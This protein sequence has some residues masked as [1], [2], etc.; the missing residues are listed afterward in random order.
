MM[1]IYDIDKL[2]ARAEEVGIFA[3]MEEIEKDLIEAAAKKHKYN[4]QR[5]A[6]SL[7]VN[8]TTLVEKRKRLNLF[9]NEK[10][11]ETTFRSKYNG[12]LE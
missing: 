12:P 1:G 6:N 8:R 9:I 4:F 7:K 3:A 2:L 10:S 11:Q 5:A